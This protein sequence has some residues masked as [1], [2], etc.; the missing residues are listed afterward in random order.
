MEEHRENFVGDTQSWSVGIEDDFEIDGTW[1]LCAGCKLE[2]I[3]PVNNY[4]IYMDENSPE[5][6]EGYGL[7]V[8]YQ[9][10][11][12]PSYYLQAISVLADYFGI[13]NQEAQDI[14]EE[15]LLTVEEITLSHQLQERYDTIAPTAVLR[16]PATTEPLTIGRYGDVHL[17]FIVTEVETNGTV[18]LLDTVIGQSGFAVELWNT[19]SAGLAEAYVVPNSELNFLN[20]G[21]VDS[22][23]GETVITFAFNP[24]IYPIGQV[25]IGLHNVSFPNNLLVEADICNNNVDIVTSTNTEDSKEV[26][27][28]LLIYPNPTS[29]DFTVIMDGTSINN[30]NV[31]DVQGKKTQNENLSPGIYFIQ[32][33]HRNV[34]FV[35]KL[36]V[37]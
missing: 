5:Y 8:Q 3:T 31:L 27:V 10:T 9:T 30:Y 25:D 33:E 37:R 36:I 23:N 28:G 12:D 1:T 11:G 14:I 19:D 17:P 32:L 2:W 7:F 13:T 18:A 4:L 35:E 34:L 6:Q 26:E 20:A 16:I 22:P 24:N 29:G 21:W 15:G